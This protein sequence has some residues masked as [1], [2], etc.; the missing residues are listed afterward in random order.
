[1][2]AGE[3]FFTGA[4]V[5][6]YPPLT[7]N[8]SRSIAQIAP[9]GNLV[10]FPA[11]YRVESRVKTLTPS[12]W[13]FLC[14]RY[15]NVNNRYQ[16]ILITD[17]SYE[18]NPDVLYLLKTLDTGVT[19]VL[20]N[21]DGIVPN[22][23][24]Q[25]GTWYKFGTAVLEQTS[26]NRLNVYL[27]GTTYFDV[28]DSDLPYSSYNGLAFE[29][30]SYN[31]DYSVRFDD[32]RVREYAASEPTVVIGVEEHV[33]TGVILVTTLPATNVA[34]TSATLN[35]NLTSLGTATT[36]NISF[37][38]GLTNTYGSTTQVQA[39]TAAG[40]F[41]ANISDLSS[42]TLYH[43][44]TKAD[45][46]T[47]GVV[48]S[49][50]MTFTTLTVVPGADFEFVEGVNPHGGNIPS[51]GHSTE[52]GTDHKS[53]GNPDGFYAILGGLVTDEED[54]D[55]EVFYGYLGNEEAFGPFAPVNPALDES[56][57]RQPLIVVK[58]TEAPGAEPKQKLMGSNN[59]QGKG[60][61]NGK[62]GAVVYHF[63]VPSEPVCTVYVNGVQQFRDTCSVSACPK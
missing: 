30:W 36:V 14:T 49:T 57:N 43:Y 52:P 61:E 34:T 11:N 6:P 60:R 22:S 37:E 5:Q 12:D 7:S 2:S 1:M 29:G 24:V 47:A 35:G 9:S 10:Q 44:R 58:F 20:A 45:G 40:A 50:D 26:T 4:L 42:N 16:S 41:T 23:P 18:G 21:P 32:F 19:T 53:G 17:T 56:G 54:E 55:I 13:V 25:M 63:I 3:Y 27:E 46:G 8:L 59:S 39:K 33:P 62:G 48:Y 38:Y 15:A 31:T 51:A 28:I